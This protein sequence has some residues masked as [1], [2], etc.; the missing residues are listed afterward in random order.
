MAKEHIFKAIKPTL[1]PLEMRKGCNQDQ[2]DQT[3]N[4]KRNIANDT[5]KRKGNFGEMCTDVD[6]EKN[7]PLGRKPE[8]KATRVGCNRIVEINTKLSR[9]IDAIY[10]CEPGPPDFIVVESKY[11][12]SD[13][14]NTK[15]GKQMSDG[16]L[17]GSKRVDKY[18]GRT[19]E[20]KVSQDQQDFEYAWYSGRVQK[21]IS[22]IDEDGNV[23][24]TIHE[25]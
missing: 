15:D 9:G 7:G 17:S 18:F 12:S 20:G 1:F 23:T 19:P 11:G 21:E 24:R 6:V 14:G 10:R 22:R 5:N 13:L 25:D 8:V 3:N 16:W 4:A 2:I